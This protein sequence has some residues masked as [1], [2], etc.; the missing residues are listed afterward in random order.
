[1]KKAGKQESSNEPLLR[2]DVTIQVFTYV[3]AYTST[4]PN[5]SRRPDSPG[6]HT[7]SPPHMRR[8]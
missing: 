8:T 1:M 7:S 6:T 4:T 2:V 3:Q 5:G